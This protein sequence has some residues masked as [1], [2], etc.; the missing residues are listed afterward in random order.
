MIIFSAFCVVVF[1]ATLLAHELAHS[2]AARK[3]GI[4]VDGITLYLFGGSARIL[5]EPQRPADEIMMAAAGPLTSFLI[6]AFSYLLYILFKGMP[7]EIWFLFY[8]LALG[9]LGVGLFNLIPAFPLDGGRLLRS[10]IWVFLK[11]RLKA[12]VVAANLSSVIAAFL[13]VFGLYLGFRFEADGFWLSAI[14]LAIFFYSRESITAAYQNE[15]LDMKLNELFSPEELKER[16]DYPYDYDYVSTVEIN[17]DIS[18][19]DLF[20][21]L[22][23]NR[24]VL[25]VVKAG[26]EKIYLSGQR[27]MDQ[28]FA[29]LENAQTVLKFTGR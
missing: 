12:T 15:I 28:I 14:S 3:K 27:L 5:R 4:E 19:Y 8:F 22:K 26:E 24:P 23:E 16:Q 25:V 17:A 20:K 7:P 10:L 13:F 18:I 1:M 6:A 11:D 9:N 29:V 2:V 21:L